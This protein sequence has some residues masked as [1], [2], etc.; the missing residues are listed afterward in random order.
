MVGKSLRASLPLF[1]ISACSQDIFKTIK[2]TN[3]S[4]EAAKHSSSDISPQY[5]A[6]GKNIRGI[7]NESRHVDFSPSPSGIC[8]KSEKISSETIT[9]NRVFMFKNRYPQH[10]FVT[11][12][13]KIGKVTL[14][15]QNLLCHPQTTVLELT[16]LIAL[17]ISSTV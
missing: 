17:M 9:T 13:E 7:F 6:D 10:V 3:S 15:F 16:K 4:T 11:N 2:G 5:S 8:H 12:R 14:K 1:W